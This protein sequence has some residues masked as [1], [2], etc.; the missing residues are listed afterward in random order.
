MEF[1]CLP[2]LRRKLLFA[3]PWKNIKISKFSKKSHAPQLLMNID[4]H[5]I[6]KKTPATVKNE[7]F[8]VKIIPGII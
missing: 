3:P 7:D 2:K 6:T 5:L 1:K 4:S 8:V